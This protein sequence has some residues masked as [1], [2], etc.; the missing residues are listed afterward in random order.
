MTKLFYIGKPVI[1]TDNTIAFV[2]I[3]GILGID[4]VSFFSLNNAWQYMLT[5]PDELQQLEIAE[6]IAH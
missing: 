3:K 1:N 5:I 2:Y 6:D 4:R